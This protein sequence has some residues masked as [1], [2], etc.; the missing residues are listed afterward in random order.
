MS[1]N[2]AIANKQQNE[3][4]YAANTAEQSAEMAALLVVDRAN[5][6]SAD[7]GTCH[8]ERADNANGAYAD[9]RGACVGGKKWH[10]CS[11]DTPKNVHNEQ[12]NERKALDSFVF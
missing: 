10:D 2:A 7:T 9:S 5:D 12:Q 11:H 3:A 1:Q 4:E 6:K 8:S